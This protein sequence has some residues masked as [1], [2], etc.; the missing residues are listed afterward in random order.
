M[1]RELERQS[2]RSTRWSIGFWTAFLLSLTMTRLY[3]E[4]PD[5]GPT[6]A[7]VFDN[8]TRTALVLGLFFSCTSVG[9]RLFSHSIVRSY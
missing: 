4:F 2:S 7:Q 6:A 8:A 3:P 1:R 5:L 9:L